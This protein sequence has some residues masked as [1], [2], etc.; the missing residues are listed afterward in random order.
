MAKVTADQ[1]RQRVVAQ[2]L[3][4]M[5]CNEY[6]GSHRQIIDVYNNNRP[7]GAYFMSYSDPWCACYVSAVAIVV[8]L[9]AFIMIAVSCDAAIEAYKRIGR[10]VEDDNYLPK[11]GD[12]I[13]YDWE[14][15]GAGDNTGSSDHT[16]IVTA[17]NGSTITVTEGNKS[18][19]V[20]QRTLARGGRF[21]RGYGVPD[22]E[23]AAAAMNTEGTEPVV[24][25]TSG[26]T[27]A[28][29]A[30]EVINGAWGNGEDRK[31]RLTAAGYDAAAVQA[32]VNAM[33]SGQ[34]VS[35]APAATVTPSEDAETT[36]GAGEGETAQEVHQE[37]TE[38]GLP[39]LVAADGV[40]EAVR[41][42]QVLLEL[43]GVKCENGGTDGEFGPCTAAA[44]NQFKTA[45][46]M[47]ADAKCDGAT[48]AA[49]ING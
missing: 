15:S 40:S 31:N 45:R 19:S 23:A 13:F 34:P 4:W 48:W 29:L 44:L 47:T 35:T 16:G 3:A 20:S 10:W 21:I 2:A 8:K 18:D 49:L 26:K 14:D 32:A 43:R 42:M 6:D 41:A 24:T 1:L 30:Q 39:V 5:G 11:P 22:Y 33:L 37:T 28:E 7:A 46:G 25:A 36:E 12:V 27:I 9:A 17:V 38:T